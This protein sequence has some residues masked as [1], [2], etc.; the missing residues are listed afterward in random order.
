MQ[1][2][3]PL[4]S[5][6]YFMVAAQTMSFKRAAEQLFV[7]QAAISQ[8]IKTL[9]QFLDRK[10]FVRGTRNVQLTHDGMLLLPD[11]EKGFKAFYQ[12]MDKL[13]LDENPHSLNITATESF[14]SRWLVPNLNSFTSAHPELSVRL[15]PTNLLCQ[16][17]DN[18][19]DVAI[20]FGK[21]LYPDLESHFIAHDKYCLVAHPS[22]VTKEWQ[23]AQIPLLP[24][25]E[26]NSA[27]MLQ[28]WQVF[29]ERYQLDGKALKR[30][31]Q[32]DDSTLTILEAALAGQGMAMLRYSL[33]YQQL[34]KNQL[35][36]VLNFEHA[37]DFNYYLVAPEHHF[38]RT[39]IIAFENWLKRECQAFQTEDMLT[40]ANSV[41]ME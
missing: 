39:K 31:L 37:C 4:N 5:L 19:L 9:E 3:P 6:R 23:P 30:A 17:K 21:G 35:V 38:K 1:K 41:F 18:D 22:L 26:E 36:K 15:Q 40:Q 24:M 2:L 33:I 12:A 11:I 25:L 28:A 34:A 32:T 14:S 7:T 13:S 16:F 29:F 27:D 10:L 20:R 8:H